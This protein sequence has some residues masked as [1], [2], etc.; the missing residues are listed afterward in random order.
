MAQSRF[1]KVSLSWS[2][3]EGATQIMSQAINCNGT[4]RHICGPA[5][6][7]GTG[8]AH[9]SVQ[10]DKSP[11]RSITAAPF[12]WSP[13]RCL[14]SVKSLKIARFLHRAFVL[15]R[16]HAHPWA[17]CSPKG[18]LEWATVLNCPVLPRALL[19][20]YLDHADAFWNQV[21]K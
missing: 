3:S 7:P 21:T 10:Y 6:V 13:K 9:Y 1:S 20:R 2:F 8:D 12:F 15:V 5:V 4:G 14:A 19:L 17:S 16:E 18:N 11:E